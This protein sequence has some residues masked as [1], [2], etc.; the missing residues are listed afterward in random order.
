VSHSRGHPGC[1]FDCTL[2]ISIIVTLLQFECFARPARAADASPNPDQCRPQALVTADNDMRLHGDRRPPG[3]PVP[4]PPVVLQRLRGAAK[5]L[6]AK[7]P[8]GTTAGLGCNDLFPDTYRIELADQR[9][10]YVAEINVGLGISYFYLV[11]H[12]P[13]TGA[14]TRNPARIGAKSPQSFGATDPLVKT[15]FVSSADLFQ[16]HHPQI[17]FEE[18]V[19]NGD[20]YNA[21]IYHYFDVGPDL[22]L[23]Q[24]LARETR[25]LALQ[26][27][28]AVFVRQLTPLIPERLRLDTYE[29]PRLHSAQRNEMGY[30][31][32]ES[33][34]PGIP[35]R[36]L[37]RHPKDP[38]KF[39]CL[40]TCQMEPPA[41]NVFL[42]TG[43]T[44]YY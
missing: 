25:L 15:P 35:F 17:V 1:R 14:A 6:I 7:V 10:L 41:D 2:V 16:N 23:T 39:N 19:H 12:D 32:V 38:K 24:V 43:Q 36:I 29:L 26:P 5:S 31:I 34:G 30:V 8:P 4:I 27:E 18:R 42:R 28:G 13:R 11:V 40:I 37:E 9:E 21:V 3:K 44:F 22:A 33:A 20:M